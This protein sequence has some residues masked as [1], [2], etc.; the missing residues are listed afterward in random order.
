M[1]RRSTAVVFFIGFVAACAVA[2]TWLL[3]L[4]GRHGP[5][6]GPVA[7]LPVLIALAVGGE[8]LLIR[9]KFRDQIETIN[10]ME[11]VLAPL[12]FGFAGWAAVAAVLVS[13]LIG[14]FVRRNTPLKAA[15][16]I[17]QWTLAAGLG[18]LVVSQGSGVSTLGSIG[19]LVVA[20]AVVG[21]VNQSAMTTVIAIAS[22]STPRDVARTLATTLVPGMVATWVAN[23]S[24]GVLFVLAYEQHAASVVLFGLPLGALH[25]AYRSAAKA[26]SERRRVAGIHDALATCVDPAEEDVTPF[27]R[28]IAAAFEARRASITI[29]RDRAISTYALDVDLDQLVTR[30]QF[31][32]D[33][34]I[35]S[36]ARGEG[37]AVALAVWDLAGLDGSDD[38]DDEALAGLAREVVARLERN[39][40]L[41]TVLEERARLAEIVTSTSDGI[42]TMSADGRVQSWNPA[43][44]VITGLTRRAVIQRRD[45]F[46]RLHARTLDGAPVALH[47]WADMRDLPSEFRITGADGETR[48]LACS[49]SHV[50]E[51][52]DLQPTMVL[53]ARDTT[54]AEEMETLRVQFGRLA[55]A[56]AAQR[57]IVDHLQQAV[58]PLTGAVPDTDVAVRYVSSDPASP[59]GGD[60]Y[61]WHVL[62]NGD[63]HVAVVDVLGHGV[64]ATRDALAVIHALRVLAVQSCPLRSLVREAN[65]VLGAER[66]DLVATVMVCRYRPS[67]GE[68]ELAGGGHPAPLVASRYG[69][70]REIEAPGGTIGWPSA[71]STDVVRGRL[72]PGDTL[73]LYTDGVVEAGKD[74]LTGTR[75]LTADAHRLAHLPADDYVVSLLDRALAGAMRRDDSLLL[76]VRRQLLPAKVREWQFAPDPGE[77]RGVRHDIAAFAKARGI[78]EDE[79]DR[80]QLVT[81]ELVTNAVR[82]ARSHIHVEFRLA[83]AFGELL[84]SDDG[85]GFE[86]ADLPA[87]V[88]VDLESE[89]G[90]GLSIV[91]LSVD[92]FAIAPSEDGTVVRAKL[93]WRDEV[94]DRPPPAEVAQ[95]RP[96]FTSAQR[97]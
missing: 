34:A 52:A 75:R 71:G 35:Y 55:E 82:N 43:L 61:D 37:L 72:E 49:Y 80:L 91:A 50:R 89:S 79:L 11:A 77:V 78:H 23:V 74:I 65:T 10:L 88:D 53:I 27:L 62:P 67:T 22:G 97:H 95:R 41:K 1:R 28:N 2:T 12:L 66:S 20:L 16:N 14:A 94:D 56:E 26:R 17:S 70:V 47:D 6:D 59:T 86:P 8:A 31:E 60:L 96:T 30:P 38:A 54:P 85:S 15:F 25:L 24:L 68:F 29:E 57:D 36:T 87:T 33:D 84:V 9:F 32:T 21:L 45:V 76:A 81:S 5:G 46:D 83:R 18:A 39:L 40:L 44:E 51:T 69:G 42:L 73:L 48:R 13:Q 19:Y 64:G 7:T 63:V 3:A 90:R 93:A 92:E 58:M 4:D